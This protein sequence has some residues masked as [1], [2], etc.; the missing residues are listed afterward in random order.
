MKSSVVRIEKKHLS[1]LAV[2]EE[3]CFSEPWTEEALA[4]LL[5]DSGVGFAALDGDTPVAYV[6]MLCVLD[7][8]Q[9]TNVATHPGYRGRGYACAVLSALFEYAEKNA[10]SEITLEVRASNT[11]AISLYEKHGFLAVGERRAFYRRP[12]ENAIIMKKQLSEI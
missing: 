7:E 3:L 5:G 9:I 10:L 6:G 8:G 4:L 12:T 11:A 2:L 1:S